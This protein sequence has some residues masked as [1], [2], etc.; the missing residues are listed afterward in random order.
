[1]HC[2]RPDSHTRHQ[3]GAAPFG[4]CVLAMWKFQDPRRLVR[5][6]RRE[7][8]ARWAPIGSELTGGGVDG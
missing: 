6:L 1:M 2:R 4:A 5:S 3:L 7:R 8:S